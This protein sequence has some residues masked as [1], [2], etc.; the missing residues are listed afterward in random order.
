MILFP[1]CYL[2]ARISSPPVRTGMSAHVQIRVT[3]THSVYCQCRLPGLWPAIEAGKYL[4]S[5]CHTISRRWLTCCV[6]FLSIR[7]C[8]IVILKAVHRMY[9]R[10]QYVNMRLLLV[11]IIFILTGK[12]ILYLRYSWILMWIFSLLPVLYYC[13]PTHLPCSHSLIFYS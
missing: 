4:H 7:E 12:W 5:H 1:P 3:L 2:G 13:L 8:S 6:K 9:L 10:C 11:R